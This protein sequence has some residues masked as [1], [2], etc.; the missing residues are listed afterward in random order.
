MAP[1]AL[2]LADKSPRQRAWTLAICTYRALGAVAIITAISYQ[3]AHESSR[4]AFH[5]ANY[6]SYFTELSNLF[7][8]A[9]LLYMASHMHRPRSATT[10]LLRGAAVLYMLTTGIVY[11]VLLSGH[12]VSLPWVNTIVHRVMPAVLVLDW[13]C[14]PPS[15]AISMRQA[16]WWLAFPVIYF[17]YTL[18]RGPIVH[19]YPYEFLDPRLSGGYPRVLAN[20]VGIAVGQILMS[21]LILRLAGRVRTI[22]ERDTRDA[23]ALDG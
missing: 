22:R 7:A 11:A 13:I 18:A 15:V 8:A 12:G 14:D 19:W 9:I 23:R 1:R 4:T 17:V 2:G 5:A 20:A 3:V 6:F 16:R 21:L 10:E